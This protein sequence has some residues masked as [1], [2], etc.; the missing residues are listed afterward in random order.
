MVRSSS[1]VFQSQSGLSDPPSLNGSTL[2]PI[3]IHQPTQ[4]E[5]FQRLLTALSLSCCDYFQYDDQC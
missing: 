4:N 3:I 1:G 2:R 5:T